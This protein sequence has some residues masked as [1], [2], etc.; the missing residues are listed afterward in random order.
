[1]I[2]SLINRAVL[3]TFFYV[4]KINWKRRLKP[5]GLSE[6]LSPMYRDEQ[7]SLSKYL[8]ATTLKSCEISERESSDSLASVILPDS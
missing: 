2:V 7:L 5:Q 3:E 4:P 8:P 6:Q 1:M